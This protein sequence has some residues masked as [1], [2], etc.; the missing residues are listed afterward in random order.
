VLGRDAI[1]DPTALDLL[2][3]HSTIFIPPAGRVTVIA[4]TDAL[5]GTVNLVAQEVNTDDDDDYF[6]VGSQVGQRPTPWNII[7]LIPGGSATPVTSWP[8]LA[9]PINELLGFTTYFGDAAAAFTA[10]HGIDATY[11]LFEPPDA[12]P[13]GFLPPEPTQTTLY[14]LADAHGSY[15]GIKGPSDPYDNY[16]PPIAHLIPGRPQRWIIQNRSEEWHMFHIHQIHFRVERFTVVRDLVNP[17][18]NLEP[19]IENDGNPFYAVHE[20]PPAGSGKVMGQPFESGLVDTVSIPDGLQAWVTLPLNEGPQIAGNFVMHCHILEHEDSGMMANVSASDNSPTA[21][22]LRRTSALHLPP[23]EVAVARFKE[24]APLHDASGRELTSDVFRRN[25]FS[26]VAFGYTT[27]EG[28]CP[29]TL[30]KCV[31]ALGRL[32]PAET[33]RISPFFVSLDIERDDAGRLR[34]FAK[35]HEL[36]SAW[37]TLLDTRLAASRAFGVQ[38]RFSRQPDGSMF[39]RHTTTIYLID[40]SMKIRA[41]F[42]EDDTPAE[43]SLRLQKELRSPIQAA[44][45]VDRA[46]G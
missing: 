46:H 4:P 38:R 8:A 15:L 28:S 19:P 18:N 12:R 35:D 20:P 13:A 2:V 17:E 37:N 22:P 10:R 42:D 9:P 36:S 43:M 41:A 27:C 29:M 3:P 5:S 40:R 26:L 32:E 31:A 6:Q 11:V 25:D 34:E 44:S 1:P 30:E 39:L 23:L 16:E 7:T 14:R 33:A 21:E 45:A 24:P